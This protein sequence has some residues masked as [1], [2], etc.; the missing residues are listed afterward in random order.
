MK[1]KIKKARRKKG[2]DGLNYEALLRVQFGENKEEPR[3]M[4]SLLALDRIW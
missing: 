3:I 4:E 2:R 1:E